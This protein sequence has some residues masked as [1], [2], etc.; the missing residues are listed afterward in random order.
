[1]RREARMSER[2]YTLEVSEFQLQVLR[3]ALDNYARMGMG[4]LDV[5]VDEF[6]RQNFYGMYGDGIYEEF[7]VV[8]N[9]RTAVANLIYTVKSFAYALRWYLQDGGSQVSF[10]RLTGEI[11]AYVRHRHDRGET[12]DTDRFALA[13]ALMELTTH[14]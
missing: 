10:D 2:K 13:W 1:L 4:Q 9:N 8:I 5:S 14:D 6:L 12:T 3:Q 11:F 7:P